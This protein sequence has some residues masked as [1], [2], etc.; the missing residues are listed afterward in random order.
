LKTIVLF[1][2]SYPYDIAVEN[3]F[4]EEELFYLNKY[5]KV[6]IIPQTRQGTRSSFIDNLENI[7]VWEDL[8]EY[9]KSYIFKI[10]DFKFLKELK[11]IKN[12]FHLKQLIIH[13]SQVK[14]LEKHIE[15]KFKMGNLKKEFIYYTFWFSSQTTALINLK[16][17]YNFKLFSRVHGGDLYFERNNGYIPF[18][19][20]DTQIID[21]VI[22]VSKQ[23]YEYLKDVYLIKKDKIELLHLL[24]KDYQVINPKNN[25]KN[26]NI[27]SCSFLVS[28]KRVNKI[29]E[30]LYLISKKYNID[31]NYTHIGNGIEFEKVEKLSFQLSNELFKINLIG[32]KTI[33]EIMD[34]YKTESF[35]YFITLS[36]T[37][38]GVPFALREAASCEIPLIGTN[39]GG[40]PEI[41]ENNGFLVNKDLENIEEILLKT[42]NLKI[43]SFEEYVKLRKNSRKIFLKKFEAGKNHKKFV[44]FLERL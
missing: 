33:D 14:W 6:I 7:E 44:E 5:F 43:N 31:V 22:A 30:F 26:F 35:D 10:L 20:K 4:L 28:L 11:N 17:I 34:I 27:V 19:M 1:T 40:I 9:K 42:Y 15:E 13:Y 2:A 32:F 8:E 37:E 23:G 39:I 12:L 16:K 18:R 3:T 24:S 38:G 41:I 36:E 25:N 21:K 29:I